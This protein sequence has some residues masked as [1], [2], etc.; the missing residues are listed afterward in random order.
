MLF[1][2]NLYWKLN[3]ID[4]LSVQLPSSLWKKI[5]T[6]FLPEGRGGW[7][8]VTTVNAH[9]VSPLD[10]IYIIFYYIDMSVLLGNIPLVKFINATSGTRVVYFP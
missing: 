10:C 3:L 6:Q 9:R 4:I 1:L 7:T 2:T 5:V 8:R